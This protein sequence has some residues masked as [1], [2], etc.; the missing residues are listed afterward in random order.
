ME[1]NERATALKDH[2]YR[3]FD[4][5]VEVAAGLSD[6]LYA[7]RIEPDRAFE[8]VS[9]SVER[10]IGYTLAE[11]YEDPDLG[12]RIVDPH[13]RAVL[14]AS[15]TAEV[16]VPRDFTIRWLTRSGI[17]VWMRHRCEKRRR[18]DGSIVLY[19]AARDVTEE[20]DVLDRLVEAEAKS[21]MLIENSIDVVFHT[22]GG[23][24]TWIS[25]SVTRLIGWTPQELIG[26]TTEH[27]W[28]PGDEAMVKSLRSQLQ[29]TGQAR[30]VFRFRAKDNH[31]VW[32]ESSVTQT[33][34]EGGF[35]AVGTLRDVSEKVEA[36]RA[37]DAMEHQ[38]RILAE[39]AG[40]F[41]V[42]EN[43]DGVMVW[44]SP[45]ITETL[46][47]MPEDF[48]GR[49]GA[50]FTHP[51]DLA[52]LLESQRSANIGGLT[53]G[54]L[55]LRGEDGSYRWVSYR[56]RPVYGPDGN[57]QSRI[58]TIRAI[59]EVVAI[60]GALARSEYRFRSAL[61]SAPIG[62]AVLD[63]E[64]NF[65]EVNAAM[66][67]ML[68]FDESWLLDASLAVVLDGENDVVD[69]AARS[70]LT[71]DEVGSTR[72]EHQLTKRNGS[73]IWVDHSVAL[74]HDADGTANGYVDQMVDVTGSRFA[75]KSL[76]YDATHDPLTALVNR[77]ELANRM[78]E[79]SSRQARTGREAAV[80]FMD[81]DGMKAI[82]DEFGHEAGDVLLVE[83]ADRIS[84]QVRAE[85][86]VSR[87]GGDE[88][89]VVLPTLQNLSDADLIAAKIQQAVAEPID[90]D[91]SRIG[92]TIS[93]GISPVSPG[94]DPKVSLAH[95]DMALYQAKYSGAGGRVT[96]VPDGQEGRD[97]PQPGR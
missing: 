54:R 31:L 86:V 40:D 34:E 38:F 15:S 83:T 48:L 12:M 42:Q 79:L 66:C 28:H 1:S 9:P 87:M 88:F 36:D 90:L 22:I 18:S 2:N 23:V 50:D 73:I 14:V 10:V 59:D 77:S 53:T 6:V 52:S 19:G 91:S 75:R 61:K 72:R 80:L 74:L 63:L 60:E 65:V 70:T 35:G 44:I 7:Y 47:W 92:V 67:D 82:N 5:L 33:L 76:E 25:P 4:T 37:R 58:S 56:M 89:V 69:R 85:D 11:F 17:E 49:R 94:D 21:R 39:N 29:E 68:G 97:E 30:G 45:A 24:V 3:G 26:R 32:I 78:D 20:H 43:P 84:H 51:D 95:A 57:L 13:D 96:Y 62:M 81:I 93:V 41:V 55:R 8:F 71:S 46:G 16:G 64:R 27:L